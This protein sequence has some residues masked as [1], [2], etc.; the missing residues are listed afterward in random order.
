MPDIINED[1]SEDKMGPCDIPVSTGFLF[2][3]E[4]VYIKESSTIEVY[5]PY[6]AFN[7]IFS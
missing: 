3:Y 2:E 5:Q 6:D 1:N 7:V 4:L